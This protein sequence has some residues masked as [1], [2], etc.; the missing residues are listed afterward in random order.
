MTQDYWENLYHQVGD[1]G[2]RWKWEWEKEKKEL[3]DSGGE[4]VKGKRSKVVVSQRE[5][6]S[7]FNLR[8]SLFVFLHK[9]NDEE[10]KILIN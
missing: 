3:E 4:K 5:C 8:W 2:S 9:I 7:Q 1:R 10:K 6:T